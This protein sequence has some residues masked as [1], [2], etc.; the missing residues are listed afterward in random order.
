MS[1]V[2][3]YD[4]TEGACVCVRSRPV[5]MV[6]ARITD[7]E[8]GWMELKWSEVD[9]FLGFY[10]NC[11]DFVKREYLNLLHQNLKLCSEELTETFNL[12]FSLTLLLFSGGISHHG[13][14]RRRSH[15]RRRT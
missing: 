9:I 4:G 14:K 6:T 3:T 11:S 10:Q 8:Q 12:K 7:P 1:A 13:E 2:Q 15:Q 5:A